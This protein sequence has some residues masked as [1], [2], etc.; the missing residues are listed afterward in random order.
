MASARELPEAIQW[1]EGMLLAPQHFQQSLLRQ[2]ELLHYH[3]MAVAPFHWGIRRLKI[4]EALLLNGT[5][6]VTDLEAIM[7]DGLVIYHPSPGGEDLE[8]D[9]SPYVDEMKQRQITAYLTV[10]ARKLGQPPMKGDLPRFSSVEGEPVVDE[11]TGE[12][13]IPIPRLRPLIGLLVGEK[14]PQ[15]YV[16][17]PLAKIH[18]IYETI[19]MSNYVPPTLSI[20]VKSPIGEICLEIA[21]RLRLKAIFLSEKMMS[22]S[23][24]MK[25]PMVL[26]TKSMIHSLVA[27]LPRFE[28]VLN[29]D[30]SHPYLLYLS[31]CSLVGQAASLGRGLLPPV[32]DPYDHNDILSSFDQAKGFINKMIEEGILVS[33]SPVPFDFENG[34]FSLTL[35]PT[36]ITP[37][38]II[39][40]RARPGMTEE[41]VTAWMEESLIG[42]R[43]KTETMKEKR[44]LGAPRKR[45]D[46]EGE[47]VPTRGACLFSVKVDPAFIE[48]NEPLDVFNTSD[49]AGQKGP[50]EVV[51]YVRNRP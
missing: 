20:S 39:G 43:T 4:D 11:N 16:A 6:R 14:P 32:L 41:D 50:G 33:H 9:L 13:E 22:P 47:L 36:W 45:I 34:V 51:L 10:P 40:T 19:T 23:A 29:T 15:K 37:A 44:I 12:G 24:V 38:L 3:L 25:G 8:V 28:A 18:Y 27:G 49:P 35:D 30:Q 17:F 48:P 5:F 1:H 46:A 21:N 2:E 42:S 26:E 31:L 7:P